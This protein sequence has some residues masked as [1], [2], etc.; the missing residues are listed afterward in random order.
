MAEDVKA[1]ITGVVFQVVAGVGTRVAAGDPIVVLES[2]LQ[3]EGNS[4]LRGV[5]FSPL[6]RTSGPGRLILRVF[7]VLMVE[8]TCGLG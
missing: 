7:I 8:T 5:G 1:H 3:S 6:K 4:S 2:I